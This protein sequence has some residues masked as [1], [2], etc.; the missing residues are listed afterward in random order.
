MFSGL[1]RLRSAP[2]IVETANLEETQVYK[3]VLAKS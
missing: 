2:T 1:E 3:F